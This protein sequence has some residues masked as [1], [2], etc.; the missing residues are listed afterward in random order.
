MN[1]QFFKIFREY[2]ELS[3]RYDE[4][5][6]A[7]WYY[8]NPTPRSCFSVTMLQ[9]LRE[10]FQ[11]VIDYFN[12]RDTSSEP[13]I[14][15]MILTSQV[16]GI[17]NL[18]GDLAL[19]SKLIKNR[20]RQQLLD[21]AIQCID[22]CYLHAVNLHLPLT[23]ISLVEGLALGGGFESALASNILIATED[24]EMGFPEIRFNLF[25][26]MSAYSFLARTCGM[27]TAEK[28]IISG[29]TYTA[30]ELYNMGVVDH[31]LK[32]GNSQKGVAKYIRQHQR[33]GNG[34]RAIEKVGQRYHPIDYQELKDITTIW[35]DAALLLNDRDL[36]MMDRLVRVQSIKIRKQKTGS[37]LRTKQDR[38]F[39]KEEVSFPLAARSEEIILYNRRKNFDRRLRN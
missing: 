13:P 39:V 19:F 21:Y 32:P 36:R 10:I 1:S 5:N 9:E 14:R 8:F 28:M 30:R 34:R 6:R 26:G 29:N 15:Y 33:S 17:F 27:V 4:K 3:V 35:V 23:T 31:L 7:L 38:R 2:K 37:R 20:D 16:P 25:P 11:S 12:T 22:L 24:A 18:G